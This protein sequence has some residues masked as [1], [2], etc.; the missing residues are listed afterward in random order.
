MLGNAQLRIR[1]RAWIEDSVT[2]SCADQD[3]GGAWRCTV[4]FTLLGSVH[5]ADD[6]MG[7][8]VDR[9]GLTICESQPTGEAGCVSSPPAAV[10]AA[11]AAGDRMTLGLVI[12]AAKLWTPGTRQLQANLCNDFDMIMD[13]SP[14]CTVSSLPP[15]AQPCDV[16]YTW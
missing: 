12:P 1:K 9:M 6:R 5:A 8:T 13:P 14:P 15:G 4:G 2:A 7:L 3:S 10:H 16:F 11:A